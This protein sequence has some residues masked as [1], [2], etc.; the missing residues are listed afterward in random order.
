M[1]YSNGDEGV[2][3]ATN[4]LESKFG[5]RNRDG[6]VMNPLAQVIQKLERSVGVASILEEGEM[7]ESS[8]IHEQEEEEE[9]VQDDDENMVDGAAGSDSD[10]DG[11]G[12]GDATD[13]GV[14]TDKEGKDKDGDDKKLE[15]EKNGKRRRGRGNDYDYYDNFIDDTEYIEVLEH[16]DRRKSKYAGFF[17]A[18]G[19][20]DRSD[21]LLPGAAPLKNGRRRRR[22]ADGTREGSQQPSGTMTEGISGDED[23]TRG[24]HGLEDVEG[25]DRQKDPERKRR[26]RRRKKD[27]AEE[28]LQPTAQSPKPLASAKE[29]SMD[30]FKAA[31][32]AGAAAGAAAAGAAA[33]A[34]AAAT[35]QP[36]DSSVGVQVPSKPVQKKETPVYTMPADV[37]DAIDRILKEARSAPPPPPT[38]GEDNA[39]FFRKQL[40]PNV[41]EVLKSS[42]G[43][44]GREYRQHGPT[45][46]GRIIEQ[47]YD[48]LEPYTTRENLRIYAI[49]GR[50][51]S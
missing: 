7:S 9:E 44:F 30:A 20:I 23:G 47:M 16:T 8:S 26:R 41:L 31:K 33:A 37:A 50:V 27:S 17:I 18:K 34:R 32:G 51:R 39:K 4:S 19:S 38:M 48:V 22:R 46:S 40:P 36:I 2:N 15:D 12:E 49:G 24:S 14:R 10:G 3:S 11:E 29:F 35:S 25:A 45:A 1:A 28:N 42:M 43:I 13:T 21:E 5:S 6:A